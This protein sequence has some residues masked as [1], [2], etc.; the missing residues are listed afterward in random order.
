MPTVTISNLSPE[1]FDALNQ[2]AAENHRTV[3]DEILAILEYD[4]RDPARE[5]WVSELAALGKRYNVK[6]AN[7]S[8]RNDSSEHIV[9]E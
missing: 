6:T 3:E 9:F 1:T 2:M 7:P 5:D 4:L 8:S